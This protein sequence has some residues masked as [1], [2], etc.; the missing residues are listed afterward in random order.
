M[1]LGEKKRSLAV[2]AL[3]LA[4]M[5][6]VGCAPDT[7]VK[8][9]SYVANLSLAEA[10]NVS[11]VMPEAR[12]YIDAL[13]TNGINVLE[14]RVEYL[15]DINL[16]VSGDAVREVVFAEDRM[17]RI[18][19][20]DMPIWEMRVT[21]RVPVALTID[22]RGDLNANL[23]RLN[24]SA[25]TINQS[26]GSSNIILPQGTFTVNGALSSGDLNMVVGRGRTVTVDISVSGGAFTFSVPANVPAQ[27]NIV[28]GDASLVTVSDTFTQSDSTWQTESVTEETAPTV[29]LNLAVSGGEVTVN[30]VE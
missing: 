9:G 10:A 27:V 7:G 6:V 11:I 28:D 24:L 30:G 13:L 25:L 12:G 1:S 23:S 18:V 5:T 17:D 16:E 14:T 8:S 26:A 29:I 4:L 15:G 3:V 20:G 22:T 2:W 21:N 19:E